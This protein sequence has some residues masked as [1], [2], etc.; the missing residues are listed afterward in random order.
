[1][2]QLYD[3]KQTIIKKITF[4]EIYV[5]YDISTWLKRKQGLLYPV[6]NTTRDQA[7]KINSLTI[8][9]KIPLHIF[10]FCFLKAREQLSDSGIFVLIKKTLN[11]QLLIK[12]N[13]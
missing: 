9:I 4:N 11:S 8:L 3:I 2:P 1:M 5:K 6:K 10:L 12:I 7:S 13:R